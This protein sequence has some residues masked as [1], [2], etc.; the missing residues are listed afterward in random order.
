MQRH[1]LDF[2]ALVLFL[3]GLSLLSLLN[4]RGEATCPKL[5]PKL[6]QTTFTA[7]NCWSTWLSYLDIYCQKDFEVVE[8]TNQ[9]CCFGARSNCCRAC[10]RPRSIWRTEP[11][12][13]FSL[14]R[15]IL[16]LWEIFILQ[17]FWFPRFEGMSQL[18]G[19]NGLQLFSIFSQEAENDL[20]L[21]NQQ[22]NAS[23]QAVIAAKSAL[24]KKEDWQ[25][26]LW[27]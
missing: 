6:N 22:L 10:R 25:L 19:F 12:R 18:F 11:V 20:E 26:D 24:A 14:L 23:S 21:K 7:L 9:G 2:K 1:W 3:F 27:I 8:T 15:L 16:F 13:S 5:E 4:L 17:A